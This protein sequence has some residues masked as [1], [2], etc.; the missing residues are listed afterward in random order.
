MRAH[1]LDSLRAI[2]GRDG[3]IQI[4]PPRHTVRPHRVHKQEHPENHELVTRPLTSP[5][6]PNG[7]SGFRDRGGSQIASPRVTNV[8]LGPFW[9]DRNVLEQFSKAV[10]E[11]GYL[12]P[13]KDLGYGTGSGTYHGAVDVQIGSPVVYSDANAKADV[14]K[15]V[16]NGTLAAHPDAL[17]ALI[18]PEGLRAQSA[19]GSLSCSDFCGYHDAVSINGVDV[20]YMVLPSGQCTACG[21]GFEDFTAIYGHELAEACTDKVP[22]QGWIADDGQENGDLEAWILFGWGPPSNPN[23]YTVQ[24]YYTNER[25]NTCG[26]WR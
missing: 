8:Y 19:D 15:W 9:A 18:L 10:V 23:L 11:S 6:G 16:S 25:G 21:G 13:L 17:F 2:G 3:A 4:V 20:A 24:G 7:A 5:T 14:A 22:G 12:D 26:S 1:T